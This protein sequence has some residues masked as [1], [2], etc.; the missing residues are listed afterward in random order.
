MKPKRASRDET[1]VKSSMTLSKIGV[2]NMLQKLDTYITEVSKHSNA[3]ESCASVED[4]GDI[5]AL[6]SVS[7]IRDLSNEMLYGLDIMRSSLDRYVFADEDVM[8][9]R[10][11]IVRGL[12]GRNRRRGL[13]I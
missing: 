4:G 5:A 9:K 10:H 7:K 3:I 6:F 11:P 12:R 1:F 8:Q 13:G 2:D